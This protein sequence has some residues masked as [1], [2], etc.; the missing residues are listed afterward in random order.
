MLEADGRVVEDFATCEAFLAAYHPGREACLLVDAHL[1]GMSGLELLQH[2]SDKPKNAALRLIK[3]FR[4][5]Q[6]SH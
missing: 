5:R 2:L 1:P 3:C 6:R 4:L